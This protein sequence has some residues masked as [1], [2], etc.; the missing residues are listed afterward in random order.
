MRKKLF[1]RD[2]GEFLGLDVGDVSLSSK[3]PIR[4]DRVLG[5]VGEPLRLNTMGE[6]SADLDSTLHCV[7]SD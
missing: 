2:I 1:A 6:L 4:G 7:F 3:R 5:A